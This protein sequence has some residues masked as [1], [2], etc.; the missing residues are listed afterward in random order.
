MKHIRACPVPFCRQFNMIN[1]NL[2]CNDRCSRLKK[3]WGKKP[4]GSNFVNICD[5]PRISD[6]LFTPKLPLDIKG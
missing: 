1:I 5:L 2:T 6:C 3:L 4:S